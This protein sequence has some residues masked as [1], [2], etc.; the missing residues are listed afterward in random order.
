MFHFN[1]VELKQ[2]SER[3]QKFHFNSSELTQGS[4]GSKRFI[5]RVTK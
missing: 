2:T 5:L 4:E 1:S 3:P